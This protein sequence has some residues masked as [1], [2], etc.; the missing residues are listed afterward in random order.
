MRMM[1][2]VAKD[3]VAVRL[4]HN[5]NELSWILLIC[6]WAE[7]GYILQIPSA[8]CNMLFMKLKSQIVNP[9]P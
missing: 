8:S 6:I 3:L 4:N 9:E 1:C 7:H 5:F 2:S